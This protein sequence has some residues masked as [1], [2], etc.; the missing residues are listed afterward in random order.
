MSRIV[1]IVIGIILC[2]KGDHVTLGVILI[3]APIVGTIIDII[4]NQAFNN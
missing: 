1:S 4:L 2:S 3:V